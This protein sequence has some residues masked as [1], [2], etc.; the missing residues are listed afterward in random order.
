MLSLIHKYYFII[1]MYKFS[2]RKKHAVVHTLQRRLYLMLYL[3][4]ITFSAGIQ[5]PKG[6]HVQI[7]FNCNLFLEVW[8]KLHVFYHPWSVVTVQKIMHDTRTSYFQKHKQS[9]VW[10][11]AMR[12][13]AASSSSRQ[14]N[15]HHLCLKF[16]TLHWLEERADRYFKQ[17]R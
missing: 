9:R 11:D 10:W 4:E 17:T 7:F 3:M 5:T 2:L 8:L 12:D 6:M 16:H 13:V 15:H 14:N 1:K